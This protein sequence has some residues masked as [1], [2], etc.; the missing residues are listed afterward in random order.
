MNGEP[1][2]RRRSTSHH[3]A[4]RPAAPPHHLLAI[5]ARPDAYW[6]GS[7]LESNRDLERTGGWRLG[8]EKEK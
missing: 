2:T 5:P 4:C 3:A 7:R 8:L 6:S 1:C